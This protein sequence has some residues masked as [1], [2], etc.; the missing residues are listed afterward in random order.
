[1]RPSLRAGKGSAADEK[2]SGKIQSIYNG[3]CAPITM[4]GLARARENRPAQEQWKNNE[5]N[6]AQRSR[7]QPDIE[8]RV[9][10]AGGTLGRR[11]QRRRAGFSLLN[12]TKKTSLNVLAVIDHPR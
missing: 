2:F 12:A 9:Q 6:N 1:M 11:C 8:A 4:Q 3:K 10:A 7:K 5:K